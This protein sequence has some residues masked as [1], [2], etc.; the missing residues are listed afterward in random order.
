MMKKQNLTDAEKDTILVV[1]AETP[2][3]ITPP[4]PRRRVKTRRAFTREQ[5]DQI[6]KERLAGATI[7]SLCE[8]Y[9]VTSPTIGS[10]LY[11][12]GTYR[13]D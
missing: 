11:G 5:V 12:I 3:R 1:E 9:G 2:T 13:E 6:R 4:L 7:Q 8:K 10:V